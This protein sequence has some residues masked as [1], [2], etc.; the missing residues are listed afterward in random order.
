MKDREH[1]E[2]NLP[3]SSGR[4]LRTPWEDTMLTRELSRSRICAGSAQEDV[5]CIEGMWVQTEITPRL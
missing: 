1:H 3:V 4:R 5:V 2:K